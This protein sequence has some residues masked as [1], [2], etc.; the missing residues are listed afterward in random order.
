MRAPAGSTCALESQE[1]SQLTIHDNGQG[2]DLASV[3]PEHLGLA[4]MRERSGGDRRR[5]DHRQRSPAP[6]PVIIRWQLGNKE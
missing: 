6:A 1:Q 2:F 5:T 4:I 3:T